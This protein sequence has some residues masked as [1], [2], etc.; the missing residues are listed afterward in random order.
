VYDETPRVPTLLEGPIWT[1][2]QLT[3]SWHGVGATRL[4]DLR[5]G[6]LFREQPADPVPLRTFRFASLAQPGTMALRA[7]GGME[8][9]QAGPGLRAPA[10]DGTF[11]RAQKGGWSTARTNND[12]GGAIA[13]A[14]SQRSLSGAGRRTVERIAS[15]VADGDGADRTA[16]AAA[17][18]ETA[19]S[20]GFER[21]LAEHR[22][23]WA[24]RWRD[25]EVS[26][27]GDPR[28]ELAVRFALF[29]VMASARVDGEAAIG[30][31]GLTGPAYGGH[32]FWDADVFVLPF[33]AATCPSAARAM[34]EY[35]IRR[36]P[37]SRRAAEARG[38]AGARHAWESARDGTDV[39]PQSVRNE[40]GELVPIR[41]GEHEE[42]IVA[43][44]A[45][46]AVHYAAWT[47]DDEFLRGPAAPLVL[48]AAR[49][50]AARVR[51]DTVDGVT[52]GHLYGVIGPDEYHE[53]VDDNAFTNVMARWNLREAARLGEATGFASEDEIQRW[54]SIA[55]VLVD[56]YDSDTGRYEQCAGF[57]AL[58]DVVIHDLAET[59]VA[60]DLLFGREFVRRSQIVKQPDVLMLHHLVPDETA[61]GSLHPNLDYYEPRCSHG[62]SLSPA[63]HASLLARAGRPDE[64]LRLFEMACYLDFDDLTGTTV[65][66]LHIATFGGVWQA[67][68]FGFAGIR[69]SR[70]GLVADPRLPSAWTELRMNFR[71]RGQRIRL[72]ARHEAFELVPEAPVRVV[73]PDSGGQDITAAGRTWR[74]TPDGWEVS[75]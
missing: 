57:Y 71:Y 7:E 26:I 36:L 65:G 28:L 32:V 55:D 8:W 9:L 3:T 75:S 16:E 39:T 1:S 48:D 56:G 29:H 20:V 60:A 15:Y 72:D 37:A 11:L 21:L 52:R 46:A 69:P 34:L 47:G 49:Y 63:I 30:P 17:R 33:L 59:P 50:W 68:S 45:W 62:S 40:K 23:A 4:F 43:D 74:R 5:T 67:L 22:A 27:G 66:G 18:L 35:R 53:P 12:K 14:A 58:D 19:Q 61:P 54:R 13:A 10:A 44:V 73:V 24:T 42:H 31:R 25:T 38:L 2:L 64:A 41:T 70:D 6:V 51:F